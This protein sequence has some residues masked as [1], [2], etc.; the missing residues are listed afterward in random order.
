M[1]RK[2]V[3]LPA[4]LV[5]AGLMLAGCGGYGQVEQGVTVA[6]DEGKREVTI[7]PQT[8]S[9]DPRNPGEY[10]ILPVQVWKLPDPSV[11]G[12]LPT[13]EARGIGLRA[14]LDVDK[15][16]IKMYNPKTGVIENIS[17]KIVEDV[18]GVDIRRR[19]PLVME[20]DPVTRRWRPVRFPI[21]TRKEGESKT[22]QVYD[23]PQKRVT[24][25]ILLPESKD[26]D[27]NIGLH[28]AEVTF[29][30]DWMWNQG[31]IVRMYYLEKGQAARFMNVTKTD[32]T[33][34]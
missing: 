13:M 31:D 5:L 20:R 28:P 2:L 27:G 33:R 8:N 9:G 6:F 22:I 4:L 12:A 26:A 11:T 15:G 29:P 1:L 10:D 18:T 32:I 21:I 14:A 23:L 19:H 25:F 3:L 34:R 16:I 24:T 7:I 30:E 17:I